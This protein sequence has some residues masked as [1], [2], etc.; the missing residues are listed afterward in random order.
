MNFRFVN[1]LIKTFL[2]PNPLK[3]QALRATSD[4]RK[5]PCTCPDYFGSGFRGK[6]LALKTAFLFMLFLAPSLSFAKTPEE[7]MKDGND[8]YRLNHFKDAF[9]EYDSLRKEGYKSA[10][11]YYNLG[12]T[13]Y[14]MN[15]NPEAILYYEKARLLSPGDEDIDHN[16]KIANLSVTDKLEVV[17]ELGIIK[18]FNGV[19]SWKSSS[20]WS[21]LC[22]LFLWISM[23]LIAVYLFLRILTIRKLGFFGSIILLILSITCFV[24]SRYR[25]S[26]EEKKSAIVFASI[27][28]VKSSPDENGKDAFYIHAGTKVEVKESLGEWMNIRLADGKTGWMKK[29]EA[30]QI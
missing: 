18:F 11:L 3:G 15:K 19:L 22:L 24:F 13:Y 29:D 2:P 4:K 9:R 1:Y 23:G 7:R 10:A 6:R 5:V 8:A 14:R 16:L 12:N 17:P 27:S 30:E 28:Y 21:S 20:S 25:H 26:I